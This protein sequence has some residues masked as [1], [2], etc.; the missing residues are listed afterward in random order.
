MKRSTKDRARGKFHELKGNLKTRVGRA[1]KSRRLQAEGI[2]ETIAGRMQEKL[3]Q[4]EKVI[5]KEAI[6]YSSARPTRVNS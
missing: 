3:G 6:R 5:E 2:G 1:T 4:I